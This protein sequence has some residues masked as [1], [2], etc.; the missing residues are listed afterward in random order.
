M[1]TD[2]EL[3]GID[4]VELQRERFDHPDQMKIHREIRKRSD[5]YWGKIPPEEPKTIGLVEASQM[6]FVS[7]ETVRR[8]IR[9]HN[10]PFE[11]VGK[12]VMIDEEALKAV[13]ATR[14]T[15]KQPH[16]SVR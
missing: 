5:L 2:A 4:L 3:L 13:M 8:I 10:L 11:T 7:Y 6:F 14:R 12:R 16:N 1:A 15:T 9:R